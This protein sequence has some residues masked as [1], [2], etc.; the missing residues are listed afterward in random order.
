MV[1]GEL[2]AQDI[3]VFILLYA[4]TNWLLRE[5]RNGSEGEGKRMVTFDGLCS[6]IK[7]MLQIEIGIAEEAVFHICSCRYTWNTQVGT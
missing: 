5:Y 6:L 1:H 2:G 3:T 7:I 4:T